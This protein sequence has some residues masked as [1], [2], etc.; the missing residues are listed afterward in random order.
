[1][2]MGAAGG[3]MAEA[4]DRDVTEHSGAFWRVSD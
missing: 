3:E 1:M 2:E 4:C